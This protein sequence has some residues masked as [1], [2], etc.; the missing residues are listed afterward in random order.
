MAIEGGAC[1]AVP[2]F[3]AALSI[4]IRFT[5]RFPG[6]RVEK[7]VARQ[8]LITKLLQSPAIEAVEG[9][10]Q[11]SVEEE[12]IRGTASQVLVGC[13]HRRPVLFEDV[14]VDQIVQFVR[15]RDHSIP[16]NLAELQASRATFDH[17]GIHSERRRRESSVWRK[18]AKAPW[19]NR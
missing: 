9:E 11:L 4:G 6:C 1:S 2:P 8:P 5:A 10:Q 14:R 13:H 19:P 7:D 17:G 15:G 12:I 18:A 3:S 16:L